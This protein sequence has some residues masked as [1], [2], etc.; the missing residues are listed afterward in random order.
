MKP[1]PVVTDRKPAYPV[2][3]EVL[4]NPDL[5][6]RHVP[7]S[8]KAIVG[9][10]AS[11]LLLVATGLA[12]C[13]RGEKATAATTTGGP[14]AAASASASG[15]RTAATQTASA[16]PAAQQPAVVAPLFEHGEG[17]GVTG[18]VVMAPPVFLS[19]EEALQVIRDEMTK[20]GVDL[21]LADV[22]L[23]DVKIAP[24]MMSYV[25]KGDTYEGVTKDS[26]PAV[27]VVMDAEDP[28][29]KIAV[30][31]VSEADYHTLGGIMSA[32]TV[33]EY[34]FKDVA[35]N[36]AGELKA[37]AKGATCLVFYDPGGM[38]KM[39]ALP[40]EATSEDW[41]KARKDAMTKGKAAS[42]EQLQLQVQDAVRWLRLQ[43][44]IK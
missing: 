21:S 28:A 34:K 33:E 1:Q 17:T 2:K 19:E 4:A 26:G 8:W 20:A 36:L 13:S 43:G 38:A 42:K 22:K 9:T 41:N 30:E 24:R 6:V 16:T 15:M 10:G 25:K 31:F 40:K 27:P 35:K 5:L 11:G 3:A 7:P 32:S 23:E 18:C 39:G 37:H 29:R 14:K 12:G 44:I